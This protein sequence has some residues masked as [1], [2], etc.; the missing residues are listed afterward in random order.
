V[1]LPYVQVD[2]VPA[3]LARVRAGGGKVLRAPDPA[4]L[5]G[6]FAVFADPQGAVLGILNWPLKSTGEGS[7]P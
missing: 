3:T 4:I 5:D 2:D 7:R 6:Q 1:W